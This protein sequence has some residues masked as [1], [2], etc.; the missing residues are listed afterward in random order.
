MKKFDMD[1]Y[2]KRRMKELRGERPYIESSDGAI[3]RYTRRRM[4]QIRRTLE[5]QRELDKSLLGCYPIGT[6]EVDDGKS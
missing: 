3:E 6:M 5:A 2:T 4:R 1:S